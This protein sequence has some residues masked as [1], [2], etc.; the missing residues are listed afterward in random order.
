MQFIYILKRIF[1]IFKNEGPLILIKKIF[2]ASK[3]KG[4]IDLDDLINDCPKNLDEI[5]IKFGTDKGS[6]DGKKTF[7]F[8]YRKMKDNPY[9][10]YLDWINRK[11]IKK[12][13][14]QL[15]LNSA[16][17]YENIFSKRRNERLKIL[18]L[19]VANG[20]SIASWHHYFPN[21]K[22]FGI[23]IKKPHKFFYKSNRVKY[24]QIDIF[25]KYKIQKFINENG[26]FDYVIDDSMN[27]K[28]SMLKNFENFFL[29]IRENG[30]Y[31]LEDT[32]FYDLVQ[33]AYK[34]IE[35]YNKEHDAQYFID[36]RTIN[37]IFTSIKNQEIN[38]DENIDNEFLKKASPLIKKLEFGKY[39]HPHAG[40]IIIHKQ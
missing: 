27:S 16:P 35:Q 11:D 8:V 22:I 6:F 28:A 20:H 9:K 5:F 25:D 15:G 40:M 10:N 37:E 39:K 36:S 38:I 3:N 17:I 21:S 32:G 23:D 24:N 29:N 13:Q 7:E 19:G 34:E 4:K 33:N 2:T 18:E 12:H 14:Y 1:Q 31:I 30:A 26:P